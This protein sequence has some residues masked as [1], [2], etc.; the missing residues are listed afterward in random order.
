MPEQEFSKAAEVYGKIAKRQ[1]RQFPKH[2]TRR[3]LMQFILQ[4]TKESEKPKHEK[5]LV[6]MEPKKGILK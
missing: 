1:N 6:P 4:L 3:E 2:V 5:P